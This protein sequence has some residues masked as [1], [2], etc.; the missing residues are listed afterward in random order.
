MTHRSRPKNYLWNSCDQ[1]IGTAFSVIIHH[2]S[3]YFYKLLNTKQNPTVIKPETLPCSYHTLWN[4]GKTHT[5]TLTTHRLQFPLS[6][7]QIPWQMPGKAP[8]LFYLH[9]KERVVRSSG[10]WLCCFITWPNCRVLQFQFATLY[11]SVKASLKHE[12]TAEGV[13]HQS[14]FHPTLQTVAGMLG[15]CAHWCEKSPFPLLFFFFFLSEK[16][17]FLWNK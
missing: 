13:P 5:H 12:L 11:Y 8:G 7:H 9:I 1:R 15:V 3:H 14:L 6:Q 4:S 17:F 10:Q 2:R 16:F